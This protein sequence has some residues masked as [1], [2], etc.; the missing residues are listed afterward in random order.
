MRGTQGS[1]G[2]QG[3]IGFQGATGFQGTRNTIQGTANTMR[4]TQGSLGWQGSI[5]FQGAT[6]F[7]GTANTI[8]GTANTMRGTQGPRGEQGGTGFQGPAGYQGSM[9]PQ[10]APGSES[11]A[12]YND[13]ISLHKDVIHS[14]LANAPENGV[15]DLLP[16]VGSH[17]NIVRPEDNAISLHD[18]TRIIVIESDMSVVWNTIASFRFTRNITCKYLYKYNS[19]VQASSVAV[20]ISWPSSWANVTALTANAIEFVLTTAADG[21]SGEARGTFIPVG[22]PGGGGGSYQIA[23]QT[24]TPGLLAIGGEDF[25]QNTISLLSNPCGE[26]GGLIPVRYAHTPDEKISCH[27]VS[28]WDIFRAINEIGQ[29]SQLYPPVASTILN[30]GYYYNPGLL[31]LGANDIGNGTSKWGTLISPNTTNLDNLIPVRHTFRKNATDCHVISPYDVKTGLDNIGY[32][33]SYHEAVF[34]TSTNPGLLKLGADNVDGDL[35]FIE[36][37]NTP[38]TCIPVRFNQNKEVHVICMEDIL[39]NKA[40][41]NGLLNNKTFIDGIRNILGK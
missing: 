29:T 3:S 33:T 28:P 41:I 40:F 30:G 17:G 4:G 13:G 23:T 11:G 15:S 25:N 5:G 10:G 12:P 31:R 39:R 19:D 1:L 27:V 37:Y 26:P 14:F 7:Q 24:V 20:P 21:P 2:A 34:N 22:S 32:G 9:G 16:H 36:K 38:P 18:G 35:A 6:G 8:Q